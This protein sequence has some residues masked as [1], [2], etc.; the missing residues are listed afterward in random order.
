MQRY[1]TKI[2]DGTLFV[3]W[4]DG[5]IEVGTMHALRD[6]FGG[7]TYEIEYDRQQSSVPWL[8]NDLGADNT[9]TFDVTETLQD[10]DF[11]EDFV[12]DVAEAPLD[13][14]GSQ[15]HPVRTETFAEKMI[16]IWESQGREE[17]S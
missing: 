12:E 11:D 2:E 13:A 9:L 15:G 14:T 5:W 16:D 1:D 17:D 3:E 7:D 4:D 8:E 6:V 10:M